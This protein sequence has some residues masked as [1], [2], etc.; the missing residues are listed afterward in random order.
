MYLF[1]PWK[2]SVRV[3]VI[4]MFYLFKGLVNAHPLVCFSLLSF[5][6][7]LML[8]SFFS[9]LVTLFLSFCHAIYLWNT[10]ASNDSLPFTDGLFVGGYWWK[11]GNGIWGLYCC[12]GAMS[13]LPC[14][15]GGCWK[16]LLNWLCLIGE[17]ACWFTGG[18]CG[19]VC[20]CWPC[21]GPVCN[22]LLTIKVGVDMP[23]MDAFCCECCWGEWFW[24]CELFL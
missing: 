18:I 1:Q 9:L 11:Y 19:D 2:T 22:W 7:F 24:N 17:F 10:L 14:G 15:I 6:T 3:W 12:G 5:F 21:W 23:I 13:G 8:F 16:C 4:K 20:C